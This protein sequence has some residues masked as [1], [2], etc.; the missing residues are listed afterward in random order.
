MSV[1][2]PV[3]T[4]SVTSLVHALWQSGRN[5]RS[6]SALHQHA[7]AARAARRCGRASAASWPDAVIVIRWYVRA[8]PQPQC[9]LPRAPGTLE[10]LKKSFSSR[11]AVLRD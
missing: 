6:T 10:Y 7:A 8:E 2:L 4:L 5:T 1:A 9:V 3:T 11:S